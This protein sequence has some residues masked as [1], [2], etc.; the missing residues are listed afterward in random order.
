[1]SRPLVSERT[2]DR[3]RMK[4]PPPSAARRAGSRAA[5][6]RCRV[7]PG[8]RCSAS[9][10]DRSGRAPMSTAVTESTMTS[11]FFLMDWAERN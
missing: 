3:P 6:V 7:T 9:E 4:T 8:M 11:E 5:L 10:T 2:H 1:M